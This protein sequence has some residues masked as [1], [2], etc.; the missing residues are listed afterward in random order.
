MMTPNLFLLYVADPARS[1]QF[2]QRLLGRPPAANFPT[3]V[4]FAFGEGFYLGLWSTS[5]RDF[6]SL[7][8]GHRSEIA[9]MVENEAAVD[10]LYQDWRNSGVV[11][12]QEPKLAVFGRTFVALD[13]D[14]HRLRVCIPDR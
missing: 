10:A 8:S 12:E 7:G 1:M 14:G 3:Y 4:A 11:I 9:F 2:Y 13:P 6:V 5:A